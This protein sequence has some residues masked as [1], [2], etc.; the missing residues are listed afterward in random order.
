MSLLDFFARRPDGRAAP[1]DPIPLAPMAAP[2][3]PGRKRLAGIVG[4]SAVAGLI[5][6]VS[7]WEGLRTEPY[8]DRLAHSILTVCYG[9][10]EVE[11]RRYSKEECQ[12]LLAGRL[13][14]YAAPVL[15]R[16]PELKGHDPQIISATSFAYNAGI[17]AYRKSSVAAHFSAG[18]WVSACNS[19]M[20]WTRA[21]GKVRQGLVNRRSA[22]RKIC[23]RDIPARFE[24]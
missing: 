19:L 14:D 17:A 21:G 18:R 6:V 7:Q 3:T 5:A 1:I 10:T 2:V 16:N 12:D 13:G 23:L 9:D 4:T 20:A 22:E 11:M 24:R 8:E 15:A